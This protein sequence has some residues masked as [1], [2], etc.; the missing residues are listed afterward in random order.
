M[1]H[2]ESNFYLQF[3][4]HHNKTVFFNTFNSHI[5]VIYEKGLMNEEEDEWRRMAYWLRHWIPN[6]GVPISKLLDRSKVDSDIHPSEVD[7]LSTRNSRE[8]SGKK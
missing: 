3:Y 8:L 6:Q 4:I 2:F 5:D 7:K 1:K